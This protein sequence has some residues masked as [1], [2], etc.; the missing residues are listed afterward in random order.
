MTIV[1]SQIA[2]SRP[3]L[4]L[5]AC[6]A[7]EGRLRQYRSGLMPRSTLTPSSTDIFKRRIPGR[8]VRAKCGPASNAVVTR[9]ESGEVR[10]PECERSR[11]TP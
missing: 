11:M 2:P 1:Y 9:S 7:L 4:M 8:S 3:K 10:V 5:D 6:L